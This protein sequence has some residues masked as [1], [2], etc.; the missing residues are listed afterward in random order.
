MAATILIVDDEAD[1]RE[2]I[3]E[4]LTDEDYR[5]VLA[6][7]AEQARRARREHAPDLILLDVWMPDSDGISL[8]R[9]WN[10]DPDTRGRCPVIMISGHASVETAVEATREGA[11]DFIEK[12]LSMARL[13]STVRAALSERESTSA[14]A[15]TRLTADELPEP[16]GR[17]EAATRL[18]QRIEHLSDSDVHVLI[19]GEPGTGRTTLARLLHARAGRTGDPVEAVCGRGGTLRARLERWA[20]EPESLPRTL[21]L[22][23]FEALAG[24]EAEALEG[25]LA[26]APATFRLIAIALPGL[27]LRVAADGFPGALFHRVAQAR[28]E[29]TALRERRDDIPELARQLAE[30]LP[31][32]EPLTWRPLSVAAQNRLRQHDWPGNLNELA[33]LLRRLLEGGGEEPVES[34][35]IERQLSQSQLPGGPLAAGVHSPLFELPLREAREAFERSYLSARLSRAEGSVGQLAED[36]GMERTHLYRKLRQLGIDPKQF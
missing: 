23:R 25:L 4:I 17:S 5:A 28:L 13:L 34:D 21:I 16:V 24:D 35:E 18:R 19:S 14:A 11:F 6:G 9:E 33:N 29:A 15:R 36:V 27:D 1:I 7:N 8:L 2:L 32:R 10:A 30:R 20:A 3:G 31:L 26:G 12:P 22:E